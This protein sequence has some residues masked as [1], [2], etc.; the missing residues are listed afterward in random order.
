MKLFFD[1][2]PLL[3][4]FVLYKTH[5]IYVA[6]GAIIVATG[7][8]VAYL[9]L[10]KKPIEK[11]YLITF[12]S[13]LVLGGL[14]LAFHDER[15]LKLKPTLV[16]LAFAGVF[17][18]A[19]WVGNQVIIQRMLGKVLNL[20]DAAWRKLD[21]AWVGFFVFCAVLN[22]IFARNFSQEVWVNFKVFGLMGL[23]LVFM[24]GQIF[25]L[26][27]HLIEPPPE[28]AAPPADPS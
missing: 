20:S 5:D 21:W 25:L 22:E 13:L 28:P 17:A 9:W 24:F 10:R 4:F 18:G 19:H 11:M 15:F 26:R 1:L 7:L 12:V 27:K 8:Q 6:T 23:S 3:V 16:N 2:F 14:T